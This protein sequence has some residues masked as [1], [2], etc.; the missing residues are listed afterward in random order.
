MSE[1]LK[2]AQVWATSRSEKGDPGHYS[3]YWDSIRAAQFADSLS[4]ELCTENQRLREALEGLLDVI[5]PLGIC[6]NHVEASEA[7]C[8]AALIKARA[9]LAQE[10]AK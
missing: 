10:K 8:R 9:V 4:A 5:G 6:T 1:T 7:A 3:E 2:K